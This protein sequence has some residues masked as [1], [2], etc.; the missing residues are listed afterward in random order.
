VATVIYK[1]KL[2]N[3]DTVPSS[4]SLQPLDLTDQRQWERSDLHLALVDLVQAVRKSYD[5]IFFDCPTKLSLTGFA[6]LTA[7]DF[8]IVPLEPADW[9]AQGVVQVT[10]AIDYVRSRHNPRLRLLG[11]LISRLK[12]RRKYHRIYCEE[13]Q[14]RFGQDV[15]DNVIPDLAGYEQA[16]THGI[17]VN[18][19]RPA[20]TEA[21]IARQLFAEVEARTAKKSSVGSHSRGRSVRTEQFV[22]A[23]R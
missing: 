7:S 12:R 5:Y 14:S 9:G 21:Q 23:Q 8:V 2:S 16:V 6:A 11:Y 20:S 18:L 3:I 13:L 4:T 15:F 1:S 19:R 17:P 10:E 22:A